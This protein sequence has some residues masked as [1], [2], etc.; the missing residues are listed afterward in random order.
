MNQFG[1]IV[2]IKDYVVEVEFGFENPPFVYEVLKLTDHE[3]VLMQVYRSSGPRT[4]FCFALSPISSY[5]RG[6]KVSR[7]HDYLK[8]PVGESVLGRVINVFGEPRDD[9]GEIKA[10]EHRSIYQQPASIDT[11]YSKQEILETG[12]KVV[13]LFCPLVKGGKIGLFGGSGV[14]KTVLL[15]EI[16]HN[17]INKDK[18]NTVSVFCGVGE[19]SRE[20]QELHEELKTS[21]VL[22]TVSLVFGTMGDSPSVRFLTSMAAIAQAEYFR[23][24]SE[25]NVLFFIDN[26]F[27]F[28]Q[29]GNELSLLLNTIP[30]EDGYQPTL[31]S[32]MAEIHERLTSTKKAFVTTVEAIYLPSD[33]ILDQ[34]V[35]AV[36]DYLD[37]SI[38][39]SR[40]IYQQGRFPAIDILASGSL[41]INPLTVNSMH[42]YVA[43]VAQSMLKKAEA[44]DRIVSLVGESELSEE[45]RTTYR[46]SKKIK[47]Y[48]T[49]N[50]FVAAEQTGRPGA[51]VPLKTT[52]SDVKDIM[53]GKYDTVSE[54]KFLYVG[55]LSEIKP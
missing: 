28:A 8:V 18:I 34:A 20:G 53:D 14:G 5:Y 36:L 31:A 54:E 52:V 3:E 11:I 33:D 47:N 22:P 27:R 43:T 37:S 16:L 55:T 19:R 15:T 13:D 51:Y 9:L 2:S 45:D 1:K 21:G 38:V 48:M 29:A 35:Q 41:L 32:E 10:V 49:Q 30:S 12:V 25:K 6:A 4:F 50:F 39:L 23:D 42:Y 24:T 26:M 7:T 46:R 17:I 40:Q 44:L